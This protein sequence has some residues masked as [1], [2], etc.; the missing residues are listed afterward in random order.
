MEKS[1]IKECLRLTI[2]LGKKK[3]DHS[4]VTCSVMKLA[5]YTLIFPRKIASLYH[6]WNR[7]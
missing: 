2:I 5:K 4:E 7:V 3:K 1:I 6:K